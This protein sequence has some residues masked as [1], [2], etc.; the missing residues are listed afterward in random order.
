MRTGL[1]IIYLFLLI[2][3][4]KSKD[5]VPGNVLP[6]KK[7]QTVLW[8]M[9]RAD[10]FL[11]D[12]VL[13]KDTSLKRETESI[14]LYQQVLVINGVT[15]EKFERSFTFYKSHPLLLKV[16]MDSIVNAAPEPVV[17][18]TR[19]D[20]IKDSLKTAVDSAIVK[21]TTRVLKKLKR[22]RLKSN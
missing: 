12:Y 7:M 11:A 4:C 9:M 1:L 8:D 16:I 13:N 20:P 15:K 10:Q 2:A 14:K 19:H 3:G 21:D 6:Q 18:T 22:L 17:D 5:A